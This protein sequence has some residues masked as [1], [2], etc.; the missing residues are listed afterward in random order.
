MRP[1]APGADL[2]GWIAL[3]RDELVEQLAGEGALL[4]RGFGCDRPEVLER[5]VAATGDAHYDTTEHPRE[6]IGKS[7][8]T[9]VAYPNRE[10][11]LWHNEDSFR[12]CWPARIWFACAQTAASGGETVVADGG[13]ILATVSSVAP[14][15]VESG[16]M[17]VRRYGGGLGLD[18]RV[19]FTTDDRDAVEERCRS[20]NISC[21]WD[22]D[23][24]TTR[25]VR[26]GVKRH[27]HSG[28]PFWVGQLLHFHPAALP[29]PTRASLN[30]L[31]GADGLPRDCRHADG[32]PIDDAVVTEVVNAYREAERVCRWQV[33]D[34]LLIDNVRAAHGRRAYEGERKLLVMLTA[35]LEQDS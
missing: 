30:T 16:L 10:F 15:L 25:S 5:V 7:V 23:I 9:P 1:A 11:L 33:G 19:V 26:P 24:L 13:K 35:P 6:Q 4:F 18:W 28:K 27:P 8:F 2:A 20:Q 14:K 3:H 31:Y 34:L 12:H 17:Y 21:S 29:A 32:S 22:G